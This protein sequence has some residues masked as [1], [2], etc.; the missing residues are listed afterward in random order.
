MTDFCSILLYAST[1]LLNTTV[2]IDGNPFLFKYIPDRGFTVAGEFGVME[3]KD[4]SQLLTRFRRLYCPDDFINQDS[5][6][7]ALSQY[8]DD[9][10]LR[11][12]HP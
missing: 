1:T 8:P 10:V 5:L 12:N 2:Y 6:R 7:L 11:G 3:S 4:E 9:P